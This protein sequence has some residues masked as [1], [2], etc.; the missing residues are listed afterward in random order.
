MKVF[1]NLKGKILSHFNSTLLDEKFSNAQDIP[2]EANHL[3][4]V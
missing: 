2:D 4:S 1:N 3:M